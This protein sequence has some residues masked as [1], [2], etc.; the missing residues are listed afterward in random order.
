VKEFS[1][2]VCICQSYDQKSSVLFFDS[3]YIYRAGIASRDNKFYSKSRWLY[4]R[5]LAPACGHP[6]SSTK[7]KCGGKSIPRSPCPGKKNHLGHYSVP[8]LWNKKK[9]KT[10]YRVNAMPAVF[11]ASNHVRNSYDNN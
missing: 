11:T 8:S 6:C 1:K 2:L 9:R 4:V 5:P 10:S 3:H 7:V